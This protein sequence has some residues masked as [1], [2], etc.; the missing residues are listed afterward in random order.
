M[1]EV[2]DGDTITVTALAAG[3]VLAS[4][5]PVRVRLLEIDAPERGVPYAT[6]SAALLASVAGPGSRV[7][8]L[9]DRDPLDRDG[10]QLLYVWTDAGVFVNRELVLA[11]L[12]TAVLYEPNERYIESMRAA[13]LEAPGGPVATLRTPD[14]CIPSGSADL[15]CGEVDARDFAVLPP[16][17]HG[18]D[19][20]RD[21]IACES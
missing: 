1:V 18:L 16:D 6:E 10:R 21:G 12:A 17:P 8:V 4:T 19:R 3:P 15:D 14:Q 9:P 7:W 13:E 20:D 5:G 11:G 2:I